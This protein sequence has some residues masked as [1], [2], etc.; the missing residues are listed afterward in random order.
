MRLFQLIPFFVFSMMLLAPLTISDSAAHAPTDIVLGSITT[1]QITI[2]WTH[3]GSS[4]AAQQK[5]VDILRQVGSTGWVNI[6]NNS[7]LAGSYVDTSLAA[8]T[9]YS[10]TVCH[11]EGSGSDSSGTGYAAAILCPDSIR[12]NTN[13]TQAGIGPKVYAVTL[14]CAPGFEQQS[15]STDGCTASDTTYVPTFN[16]KPTEIDVFWAG[17]Q[18][19][20]TQVAGLK[21]EYASVNSAGTVSSF[22]TATTNSTNAMCCP[23]N[24]TAQKWYTITG[25]SA[26]TN[27]QV[28]LSTITTTTTEN[29]AGTAGNNTGGTSATSLWDAGITVPAQS[30]IKTQV[31]P[32]ASYYATGDADANLKVTLKENS[33]WDRILNVALYTNISAGEGIGAS[34]TS[35]TW[36][37]FD[38]VSV[39]DPNNY[40]NDVNVVAEQSGVR[41]Q[42]FTYEITWNKPLGANSAIIETKDFQSNAGLT[43]IN[44]AWT[45]FPVT[46]VSYE[47]PEETSE[48]TVMALYDDGGVMNHLFL[49]N[50]IDY[51]LLS[52]LQYFVTDG[53]IDVSQDEK[54]VVQNED[55]LVKQLFEKF[56]VS[57]DNVKIGQKYVKTLVIS[58]T[59]NDEFFAKEPVMFSISHPDGTESKINAYTTSAG[60]FKVPIIVDKFESGVYQFT[61]SHGDLLGEL[62]SYKH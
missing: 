23:N 10:Y 38:G 39:T 61:P 40:F 56:I 53:T 60:T 62:F 30:A 43:V 17:H 50:N 16:L 35:I 26:D 8:G 52:D 9:E 11:G 58:G 49:N 55:E 54:T 24:S 41:T 29:I 14:P 1:D 6:L 45:S 42:D 5:D 21:V 59:V 28:R 32:G 18:Y 22:T 33:G 44:E 48:E 37:F 19:N 13:G 57:H 46:Q 20:N 34:D 2:T 3:A 47:V 31:G 27:Y 36:N 4:S 51:A 12:T 7:T 25:L 15:V